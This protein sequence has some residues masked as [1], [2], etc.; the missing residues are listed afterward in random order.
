MDNPESPTEGTVSSFQNGTDKGTSFFPDFIKVSVP[1]KAVQDMLTLFG[2]VQDEKEKTKIKVPKV[3]EKDKGKKGDM[4]VANFDVVT[5]TKAT[6]NK[7]GHNAEVVDSK[8]ATSS[9]KIICNNDSLTISVGGIVPQPDEEQDRTK[10]GYE[11][12]VNYRA[13]V[14]NAKSFYTLKLPAGQLE[15][16]IDS[17]EGKSIIKGDNF[18]KSLKR[19]IKRDHSYVEMYSDENKGDPSVHIINTRSK[20]SSP[21]TEKSLTRIQ[22]RSKSRD[23]TPFKQK[24]VLK[25]AERK[26]ITPKSDT[27]GEDKSLKKLSKVQGRAKRKMGKEKVKK[28]FR[29]TS[30]G[31]IRSS[32]NK[33][34]DEQKGEDSANDSQEKVRFIS[35]LQMKK[36]DISPD[37]ENSNSDVDGDKGNIADESDEDYVPESEDD[38]SGG[39]DSKK[40]RT[41]I[42]HQKTKVIS[43]EKKYPGSIIRSNLVSILPPSIAQKKI[44]V[45]AGSSKN[46]KKS[47]KTPSYV[48]NPAK[49]TVSKEGKESSAKQQTVSVNSSK[50]TQDSKTPVS[51]SLKEEGKVKMEG[52]L[53][54]NNLGP[55]QSIIQKEL[56]NNLKIQGITHMMLAKST[57]GSSILIPLQTSPTPTKGARPS[58][59]GDSSGKQVRVILVK[60]GTQQKSA[61]LGKKT[62]VG[63]EKESIQLAKTL[64]SQG[65]ETI[66]NKDPEGGK[67]DGTN[68]EVREMDS[69]SK[70]DGVNSEGEKSNEK[71]NKKNE[72]EQMELGEEKDSEKG[73][74]SN[75]GVE[76]KGQNLEKDDKGDKDG[77][78]K[79]SIVKGGLPLVTCEG[80]IPITSLLSG[81]VVSSTLL[82]EFQRNGVTHMMLARNAEN[83]PL[84]VPLQNNSRGQP[85][86][87]TGAVAAI[88]RNQSAK[89][90]GS[91]STSAT[92]KTLALDTFTKDGETHKSDRKIMVNI[93]QISMPLSVKTSKSVPDVKVK[94][95]VTFPPKQILPGPGPDTTTIIVDTTGTEIKR[96]T[97]D[98]HER[99]Q[100]QIKEDEEEAQGKKPPKLT[101]LGGQ[102]ES[103]STR[104][105]TSGKRFPFQHNCRFC[106]SQFRVLIDLIAHLEER[107]WDRPDLQEELEAVRLE[108]QK[109]KCDICGRVLSN[110][111]LLQI[112]KKS[113][114]ETERKM[115]LCHLCPSSFN[116]RHEL[117][118]HIRVVHEKIKTLECSLCKTKF[119]TKAKMLTHEQNVHRVGRVDLN[120]C[121]N[122]SNVFPSRDHLSQHLQKEHGIIRSLKS[123]QWHWHG[124]QKYN[125]L[126]CGKEFEHEMVFQAHR[127]RCQVVHM[128]AYCGIAIR[129]ISSIVDHVTRI[130][131]EEKKLFCTVCEPERKFD[132]K[133]TKLCHDILYHNASF[134]QEDLLRD[135]EFGCRHCPLHFETRMKLFCHVRDDHQK[136]CCFQCTECN[137][138]FFFEKGLD[139]HMR[140][141]EHEKPRDEIF[142]ILD[143]PPDSKTYGHLNADGS[144]SMPD[145]SK[146]K[147][148]DDNENQD[149]TSE[150]EG[151]DEIMIENVSEILKENDE[152]VCSEVTEKT[153]AEVQSSDPSTEQSATEN[154][155][156]A[157]RSTEQSSRQTFQ[158]NESQPDQSISDTSQSVDSTQNL[159]ADQRTGENNAKEKLGKRKAKEKLGKRKDR[160]SINVSFTSPDEQGNLL[161]SYFC[162]FCGDCFNEENNFTKHVRKHLNFEPFKCPD[163]EEEFDRKAEFSF[164]FSK[165]HPEKSLPEEVFTKEDL[166]CIF[167]E[168]D[169]SMKNMMI[170]L[171]ADH[172]DQFTYVCENVCKRRF[173]TLEARENHTEKCIELDERGLEQ[174]SSTIRAKRK[175]KAKALSK[176]EDELFY[177]AP[178]VDTIGDFG[179]G[180][181]VQVGYRSHNAAKV[182]TKNLYVC[183]GKM[184][185]LVEVEGKR[186]LME[187]SETDIRKTSSGPDV[188]VSKEKKVQ[189]KDASGQTEKEQVKKSTKGKTV[190]FC[191][192]CKQYI[193]HKAVL[194]HGCL[195]HLKKETLIK[196]L[197]DIGLTEADLE[198]GQEEIMERMAATRDASTSME[199]AENQTNVTKSVNSN[200]SVHRKPDLES[201]GSVG[202]ASITDMSPQ[203][204]ITE[205][206]K[207]LVTF[208][209][210]ENMVPK[211]PSQEVSMNV[212]LQE[213]SQTSSI[214][215]TY[216]PSPA[217][218]TSASPHQ[219]PRVVV[220]KTPSTS[221]QSFYGASLINAELLTAAGKKTP[222]KL[223]RVAQSPKMTSTPI[224]QLK[225]QSGVSS[226]MHRGYVSST[227]T[228]I[229]YTTVAPPV[230]SFIQ[231]SSQVEAKEIKIAEIFSEALQSE[232][233]HGETM[234]TESGVQ[235]MEIEEVQYASNILSLALAEAQTVGQEFM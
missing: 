46:D 130:H 60:Q 38:E 198:L 193:E 2:Q 188:Q 50:L 180:K 98:F 177:E 36:K 39:E 6:K 208:N 205:T 215:S 163:C 151:G 156:Q 3:E 73:L 40:N 212:N 13:N 102:M 68:G 19:D 142:K 225:V 11:C 191:G 88:V 182:V 14:R 207:K 114:H 23:N 168:K 232:G 65:S 16:D 37:S 80:I 51:L 56:L 55:L 224:Q 100:Q 125:C 187:I 132:S 81:K 171:L 196:S 64:S 144:E 63:K 75:A 103:Y 201:E 95:S 117:R 162:A 218:G 221:M 210:S 76:K 105:K 4:L 145:G 35:A 227:G 206:T 96:T 175:R 82:T 27:T 229:R 48:P 234:A 85:I 70:L 138:A 211:K 115:E 167:C 217:T 58:S 45:S 30:L 209:I 204:K 176:L 126:N 153:T 184:Y 122:C 72:L 165:E 155:N 7:K 111:K 97:H 133:K 79:T 146:S 134:S 233:Q 170:H 174:A 230:G 78:T 42:V 202:L 118:N 74:N 1:I 9:L 20:M 235:D 116:R 223:F 28:R 220:L 104:R 124:Q 141:I 200:S 101:A 119:A 127:K 120:K 109:M 54:I 12:C 66:T 178:E 108:S 231:D 172:S 21:E 203:S 147:K 99:I 152:T 131:Y 5:F 84:L 86:F 41:T 161:V 197:S 107:H 166:H 159:A 135:D 87:P 62:M 148:G 164:H 160:L 169:L 71:G 25:S 69:A 49:R 157:S 154:E 90:A 77:K 179:S 33:N 185:Q 190:V 216:M 189:T 24:T 183:G 226:L 22:T 110:S 52:V 106:H 89:Q 213:I 29:S 150:C 222:V 136:D 17:Q 143:K 149:E 195:K 92:S 44:T 140:C 199:P 173:Q 18:N 26:T 214:H 83:T 59:S 194:Q 186:L 91:L 158:T 10:L 94:S 137:V 57:N 53:N 123:S 181:K 219:N 67:P 43:T 31:H 128:C 139:N 192:F 228:S 32:S 61:N 121:E 15:E 112:H 93:E 47:E 113:N 34:V 129:K 8:A